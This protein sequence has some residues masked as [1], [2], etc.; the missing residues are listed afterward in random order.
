[1]SIKQVEKLI[2]KLQDDDEFL[3]NWNSIYLGNKFKIAKMQ[4]HLIISKSDGLLIDFKINSDEALHDSFLDLCF[5]DFYDSENFYD[6]KVG[7]NYVGSIT[8][9]SLENFG[10]AS[11]HYYL[12]VNQDFNKYVIINAKELLGKV[13]ESDYRTTNTGEMFIGELDYKNILAR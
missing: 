6:L 2:K 11:N 1:M 5:G 4:E 8:K 10:R 7:N 9:T 13:Q 12:C 3:E